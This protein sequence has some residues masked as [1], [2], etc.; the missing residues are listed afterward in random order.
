MSGYPARPSVPAGAQ[1]ARRRTGTSL[2]VTGPR[3]TGD[4]KGTRK[5]PLMSDSGTRRRRT[6]LCPCGRRYINGGR[7]ECGNCRRDLRREVS[8][9]RPMCNACG[10][11][12]PHGGNELCS[13]CRQDRHDPCAIC[14]QPSQGDTCR[15]CDA[16]LRRDERRNR[17]AIRLHN[18]GLSQTE[19]GERLGISRQRVHQLLYPAEHRARQRVAGRLE[20]PPFCQRCETETAHLHAHHEDYA[21]PLD[22]VWLCSSC[23]AVVHPHYPGIRGTNGNGRQAIGSAARARVAGEVTP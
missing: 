1:P 2:P 12:R 23:H 20:R 7:S 16:N 15:Q 18:K 9:S 5:M 3:R 22:V 4:G 17:V 10:L 21:K 11:V 19:I 13:G 6:P 14:G 8:A